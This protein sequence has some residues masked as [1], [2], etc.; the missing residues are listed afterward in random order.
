MIRNLAILAIMCVAP[1]HATVDSNPPEAIAIANA[2][3]PAACSLEASNPYVALVGDTALPQHHE[4]VV[5]A[6]PE[7]KWWQF[8]KKRKAKEALVAAQMKHLGR[9]NYLDP[10]LRKRIQAV[11]VEMRA[12]GYDIRSAEGFRSPERQ[13]ELMT[14]GGGVT[15]VGA[16]RSCHQYGLALDSVLIRNGRPQWNMKDPWTQEGYRLFGE[17]AE[18]QGLNWGGRWTYP[19]DYVH[20]ELKNECGSAKRNPETY[21]AAVIGRLGARVAVADA[22]EIE[23]DGLV[24]NP[25]EVAMPL[26]NALNPHWELCHR[27]DEYVW[28]QW[29]PTLTLRPFPLG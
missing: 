3:E 13:D 25:T 29:A 21:I 23:I 22:T 19:K 1:A 6:E 2:F 26:L 11:Y 20:V 18:A 10:N 24:V 27:E 9:I 16:M 14:N 17:L 5:E 4:P 8:G 12:K 28:G 7:L 15:S